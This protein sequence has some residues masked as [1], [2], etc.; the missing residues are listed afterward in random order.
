MAGRDGQVQWPILR[1]HCLPAVLTGGPM[2]P[3]LHV[4]NT[5]GAM[6]ILN[7]TSNQSKNNYMARRCYKELLPGSVRHTN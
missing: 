1:R 2:S 4:I 6:L 5:W 3:P 7:A